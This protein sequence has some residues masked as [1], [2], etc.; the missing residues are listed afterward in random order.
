MEKT[1]AQGP[2]RNRLSPASGMK[3]HSSPYREVG[4][5]ARQEPKR[6]RNALEPVGLV[7]PNRPSLEQERIKNEWPTEV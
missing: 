3:D 1:K 4:I 2:G 5:S 7:T 6:R